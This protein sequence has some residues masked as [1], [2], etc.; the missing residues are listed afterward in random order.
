MD[1]DFEIRL[2]GPGDW[3]RVKAIYLEGIAAGDATFETTAPEWTEWDKNHLPG[4]RL[5]AVTGDGAVHGWAALSPVSTRH[6]YSG[7]AEVSIYVATESRGHG[8][9]KK[10]L[11]VLIAESE[12]NDIWTLQASVFPE[13]AATLALHKSC[14][15][16]LVGRRERIG[17]TAN[18]LW[19]DTLL[20]EYRSPK[21]GK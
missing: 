8:V 12:A 18:G 11:Q 15:F 17:R 5:V 19:R 13:N 4:A 1:L 21:V 16:R 9:G 7:V 14:G 3:D 2:M 20:L 10:L 6:A